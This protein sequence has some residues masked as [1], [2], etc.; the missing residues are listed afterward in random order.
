VR[1]KFGSR[2][3]LYFT[4]LGCLGRRVTPEQQLYDG[5]QVKGTDDLY[6]AAGTK[7]HPRGYEISA[8]QKYHITETRER[9]RHHRGQRMYPTPSPRLSRNGGESKSDRGRSQTGQ[10]RAL[11][12]GGPDESLKQMSDEPLLRNRNYTWLL[13]MGGG[14]TTVNLSLQREAKKGLS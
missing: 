5:E 2:E 14:G 8:R 10:G 4:S 6:F 7:N 1:K 11:F 3:G 9:R 12:P 13:Q